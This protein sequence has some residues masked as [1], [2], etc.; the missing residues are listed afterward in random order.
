MVRTK[1]TAKRTPCLP[2]W[3][4]RRVPQRKKYDKKPYRIK[5]MLP[6]QK[7]VNIKKNGK[8][9]KTIIVRRKSNTSMIDGQG[10]FE[11]IFIC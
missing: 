10:H 3:L 6:E 2:H 1:L 4:N 11:C 9:V 5:A 8:V 7:Q